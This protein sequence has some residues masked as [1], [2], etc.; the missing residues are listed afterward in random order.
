MLEAAHL[1]S[2]PLEEQAEAL[3]QLRQMLVKI[4]RGQEEAI[5]LLL[6]SLCAG[7]HILLEGVPGVGKTT[8]ARCVAKVLGCSFHRIQFTADMLPSDVMGVQVLNPQSHDF[9]FK[10]GPIFAQVVLAD[11]INRA[12]PKTQSALLEAMGEAKVSVEG[13]THALPAPFCVI[14]TQNPV[15]QHGAYPL[16]ESQL[17]RFMVCL[18]LGYPSAREEY[19]LLFSQVSVEEEVAS[20]EAMLDPEALLLLQARVNAVKMAEPV[21]QYLLALVSAS[22][23]HPQ[24]LLGCSPRGAMALRQMCQARALLDGRDF[25]LPDDVKACVPPVLAHRLVLAGSAQG[26]RREA[27]QVLTELLASV[28]AP[29]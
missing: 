25:V 21:A 9:E 10:P 27:R 1:R 8:L 5:D 13:I 19:D 29:R 18:P 12:P 22:R 26:Q 11:E 17:D 16:P 24:V 14:A 23:E 7:G 6:A 20:L 15:E 3:P 2:L 28:P 4:I